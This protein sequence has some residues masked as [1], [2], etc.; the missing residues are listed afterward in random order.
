MKKIEGYP[1]YQVTEDGRVFS[2]DRFE[3]SKNGSKRK[4]TGMELKQRESNCGY[5]RVGLR[6]GNDRQKSLLVHRIVAKAFVNGFKDCLV[7]NHIDGD[8]K[9]NHASNLEWVTPSE[10]NIHAFV[11]GL[12]TAKKG[13]D[14]PSYGGDIIATDISSGISFVIR[15]KSDIIEKGF[16]PQSVYACVN[17]RLS[18][19]SGHRF[20]REECAGKI[21]GVKLDG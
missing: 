9:N 2:M 20:R 3:P 5:M 21:T 15:G 13:N 10:N 6:N 1:N 17:G 16:T 8:K 19:H 11:S 7:V 4:R 18:T 14:S 12:A